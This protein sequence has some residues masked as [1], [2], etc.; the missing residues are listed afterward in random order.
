MNRC[1]VSGLQ[2]Q[3][4]QFQ[5]ETSGALFGTRARRSG[6]SAPGSSAAIQ[7][8]GPSVSSTDPQ[9][10]LSSYYS[11][12]AEPYSRLWGP[13]LRPM[14]ETLVRALSLGSARFVLDVGAGTGSL[15]SVLEEHAPEALV[16]GV[17]LSRGMLRVARSHWPDRSVSA[18]DA[19]RLGLRADTFDASL[20]AFVLFHVPEPVQ[21]LRETR[22]VLRSGA[23]VGTT[24]WG[25]DVLPGTEIWTEELDAHG[26]QPDTMPSGVRC[27]ELMDDEGKIASLFEQAR[28]TPTRVWTERF[29]RRWTLEDLLATRA[30]CGCTSRRLRTLPE[31]EREICLRG[32]ADRLRDLPESELLQEMEVVFAV[33]RK[34]V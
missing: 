1:S 29:E 3:P 32:V 10:L 28:L 14:G 26:A 15:A 17:D 19:Q 31:E 22:R 5:S 34:G 16:L 20:L 2:V 7:V 24:T 33:G 9:A 27:H 13:V 12:T 25:K 8:G 11:R 18:M 23:S 6:E 4:L 21:A 30:H